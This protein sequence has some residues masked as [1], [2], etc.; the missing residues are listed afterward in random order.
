MCPW[1]LM[2]FPTS[3]FLASPVNTLLLPGLGTGYEITEHLVDPGHHSGKLI[4]VES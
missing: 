1:V 2:L 3:G 4:L